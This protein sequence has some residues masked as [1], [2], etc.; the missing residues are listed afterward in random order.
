MIKSVD[1]IERKKKLQESIIYY[2]E[3]ENEISNRDSIFFKNLIQQINDE[4]ICQDRQEMLSFLYMISSISKHH[5]RFDNFF[6][7]IENLLLEYKKE[8]CNFFTEEDF[9][10]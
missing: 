4:Q 8:I 1:Y 3:N 7:K 10:F 6:F 5:R 2:I 9:Q